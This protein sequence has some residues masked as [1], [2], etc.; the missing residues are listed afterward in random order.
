MAVAEKV[1][2]MNAELNAL[3]EHTDLLEVAE[4]AAREH[5]ERQK[6]RS[7]FRHGNGGS[8]GGP[9]NEGQ[10]KSLGELVVETKTY[11]DWRERGAVGGIDLS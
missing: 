11:Q 10:F 8:G 2:A 4:K 6:A 1:K 9:A 5:A 7:G 3:G